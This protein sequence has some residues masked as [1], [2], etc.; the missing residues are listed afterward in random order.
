MRKTTLTCDN[1]ACGKTAIVDQPNE[2]PGGWIL[3]SDGTKSDTTKKK[4]EVCSIACALAFVDAL[5]KK[6]TVHVIEVQ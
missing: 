5:D 2:R 4:H 3:I 1:E 6:R